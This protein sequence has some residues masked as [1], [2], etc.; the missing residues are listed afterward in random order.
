MTGT[1]PSATYGSSRDEFRRIPT[2]PRAR[3]TVRKILQASTDIL[4][5]DGL[6]GLNTN[7]VAELAGVN[8]A[9]VY[10]YFPDKI[11]ILK[12]LAESFEDKRSAYIE[13]R[14][15]DLKNTD[16]W[17]EWHS[18]VVDRM[19]QFRLEEPG[20]LAIRRALLAT[21]DL[22]YIDDDST[23]RSSQAR[24]AGLRAHAPTI[25]EVQLRRIAQITTELATSLLDSAFRV[26]PYCEET[27]VELKRVEEA[28]LSGYLTP[29][30]NRLISKKREISS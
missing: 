20:G 3:K 6:A 4:I 21:P 19:V 23:R 17:I 14:T 22:R 9:T 25:D 28:Y 11:A 24:F 18:E 15:E 26:D 5:N 30:A 29:P 8:V 13:S 7:R 2:Q 16:D 12:T 27:I 1:R 10:S